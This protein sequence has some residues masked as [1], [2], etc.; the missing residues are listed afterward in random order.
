MQHLVTLCD[1]LYEGWTV[2]QFGQ[3]IQTEMHEANSGEVEPFFSGYGRII[4]HVCDSPTDN[5]VAL[6]M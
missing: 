2:K 6:V 3:I 5:M 1:P 4:Q